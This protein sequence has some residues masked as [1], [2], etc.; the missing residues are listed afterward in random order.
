MND[1]LINFVR[2]AQPCS[3]FELAGELATLSENGA[4]WPRA[5]AEHWRREIQK[6]VDE[7]NLVDD[8]GNISVALHTKPRQ[9]T[10]FD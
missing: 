3:I 4:G 9:A 8:G 6:L 1:D 10:L 2:G 5:S 7:G